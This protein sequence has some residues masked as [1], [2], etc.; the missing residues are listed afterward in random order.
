MRYILIVSFFI[1]GC[2]SI[3]PL[4]GG[5]K[6]EQPPRVLSTSIDSAAINVSSQIFEFTFDEYIQQK[7]AKEKLLI[8]PNQA[9]PPTI[10]VKK[11]KLTIELNDDLLPNTTYT[12]QF[13]GAVTDIN[14][15]NLLENYN[16]IFSTGNYIDSAIYRGKVIDYITKKPCEKCNVHLYKSYSDTTILK[17]RPAYLART[18]KAGS[19]TFNNLPNS[20]FT[21]IALQDNNKNFYFDKEE[22]ISL[23]ILINTDSSRKDSLYIFP[24]E[25][26][27]NYKIKFLKTT[28]PGTYNFESNKPIT[29]DSITLLYNGIE[30]DYT[31]STTK[32][33][34][35]AIYAQTTDTLAISLIVQR[36]TFQFSSILNLSEL[37]YNLN[38]QLR[39]NGN[40]LIIKS[41][42]PILSLDTSAIT[43]LLDSIESTY[44]IDR[45]DTFTI[46][47][48]PNK[49]FTKAHVILASNSLVDIYNK[50][51][52]PDTLNYSHIKT[53]P[54][55]VSIDIRGDSAIS[56][57]IHIKT[58]DKSIKQTK[59]THT[60]KLIFNDL[61]P[62]KYKVVIYTDSN[63][64]GVWDTGNVFELREPE[65]ITLSEEFEVRQNW[66][67]ELIINIE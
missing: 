51:N 30:T 61:Q 25:N 11:K 18:D 46:I 26:T 17:N 4:T 8:S 13:N 2:A 62:G 38:T 6:D 14:E 52:K 32:N 9:K 48:N 20:S 3:Q 55:N 21:A 57:L 12:F 5:D 33:T 7:Q 34:L 31:L 49:V 28:I 43:L 29:T 65:T 59:I 24:N 27:E 42:T 1:I 37:K 60:K 67:K 50:P 58:G 41:K 40:H 63:N 54:T 10:S 23:P 39:G 44:T 19:F 22:S 64:N 16:F 53:D 66:D 15:G 45:L 36:D 47:I 35:T 56:Y